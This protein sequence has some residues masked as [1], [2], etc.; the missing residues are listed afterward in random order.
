VPVQHPD[1][2]VFRALGRREY[3]AVFQWMQS[4]TVGRDAA[5]VDELWWVEHLPVFTQGMAGKPEHVLAPGTIPV[6]QVDRGGQVTYHGPGQLVVYCLLDVR[7][8][9][10]GVRALVSALE[11]AVIEALATYGIAAHARPAAPGVYVGEAKIASLGL[12]IRQGCSYH[13]LSVNV[14][15]D[16]EPFSRINPCGYPGLRVTQLRDFGIKL[17][18]AAVAKD[19]LPRLGRNLGYSHYTID[20]ERSDGYGGD[21]P[22]D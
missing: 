3:Q 13:G 20:R 8:L 17:T 6:I 2:L 9:G 12:R 5:T 18:L 19:L 16:L 14:D 22:W 1:A 15:M 11:A 7:R 4:F 10:L 21:P